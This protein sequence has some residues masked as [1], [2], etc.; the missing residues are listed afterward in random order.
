MTDVTRYL[1]AED[2]AA[3]KAALPWA[4]VQEDDAD[5]GMTA[6]E[7]IKYGPGWWLHVIG[8]PLVVRDAL[9][10]DP[11]PETGE[12]SIS[13]PAEYNIGFHANLYTGLNFAHDVPDELVV[14]PNNPRRVRA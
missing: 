11:D 1:R 2:E 12:P 4:V 5:T 9:P 3:M 8:S 13:E 10:G 6:G 7:W 14:H